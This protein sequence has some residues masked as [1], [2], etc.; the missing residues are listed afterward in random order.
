MYIV[1]LIGFL[2]TG[3]LATVGLNPIVQHDDVACECYV[4]E[5]QVC[6]TGG[7]VVL[8][9]SDDGNGVKC[10]EVLPEPH[11]CECYKSSTLACD[12][13]GS[14]GPAE[15]PTSPSP[16]SEDLIACGCYISKDEVCDEDSFQ[17]LDCQTD[18]L[19]VECEKQTAPMACE[20]F[21][22]SESTCP[23]TPPAE[24]TMV[25]LAEAGRSLICA[26]ERVITPIWRPTESEMIVAN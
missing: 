24:G 1:G 4:S 13:D 15:T 26:S 16:T 6:E 21:Q 14:I 23:A 2:G 19:T 12:A 7:Y 20:C 3:L 11:A 5:V 17:I 9:C 25:C 10:D 22:V 8:A 18:G